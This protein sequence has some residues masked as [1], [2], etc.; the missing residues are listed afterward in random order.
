MKLSILIVNW[1]SR[2]LLRSCLLSI[3]ATHDGLDPQVIVV[4]G[5]SFDGCGEM[6]A[7]GFPEVEFVQ[8]PDNIGFGRANN[9]GFSKVAGETLLLLNPDTELR[10]GALAALLGALESMPGTGLVGARLLDSDGGNQLT[11]IHPAPTPWN[12]AVDC[13]WIRR[14]WWRIK[15]PGPDSPPVEVEAVS[16]ACMMLRSELFRRLGGF[17][18]RYFMYAEDMDLCHR[19]RQAGWAIRHVPGAVVVHHGGGSSATRFNGFSTVMLREALSAYM[20]TNLGGTHALLHRML[21]AASAVTRIPLL[22][23][24]CTLGGAPRRG[25]RALAIRKWWTVLRWSLGLEGWAATGSRTARILV[26]ESPTT[27]GDGAPVSSFRQAATSAP[28]P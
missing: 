25:R 18:P 20:R 15:G 17:D 5:G 2:E 23:C 28:Q 14:R 27:A 21:T 3:R 7:R 26:S 13:D 22:A 6:L 16:G 12:C 1:N 19:I 11:S 8:C 4:D 9:L 10:P 24:A